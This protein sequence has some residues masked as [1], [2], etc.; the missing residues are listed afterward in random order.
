MKKK[1]KIK[2]VYPVKSKSLCEK[3][4]YNNLKYVKPCTAYKEVYKQTRTGDEI[5]IGTESTCLISDGCCC[6]YFTR[7]TK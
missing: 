3:C 6:K 1:L 5:L 2:S 4:F 7:K